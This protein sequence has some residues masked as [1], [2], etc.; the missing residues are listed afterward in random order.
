M[1]WW[2][3]F[4]GSS[5]LNFFI[6][7]NIKPRTKVEN[8]QKIL[9]SLFIMSTTI[10]SIF[11]RIDVERICYFDSFI[12][13]TVIGRSVATIGEISFGIQIAIYLLEIIKRLN[14][15]EYHNSLILF[16]ICI[17]I[18]QGVCWLGVLTK[19]QLFHCIEESIWTISVGYCIIPTIVEIIR[20]T[21]NSDSRLIFIT[22]LIACIMYIIFMSYID[23]PMYYKRYIHNEN[24]NM[25]YLTLS[26][27][28]KDCMSCN[29][30]SK[31]WDIWKED[32]YWMF[33][34]FS[35]STLFSLAMIQ[36]P[37]LF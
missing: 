19:Y 14:I 3:T 22:G 35:L 26:E 12:S 31:D 28:I 20:K 33:G 6:L 37:K 24:D 13:S 4:V 9:S 5:C 7:M 32:Y 2:L 25:K 30:I 10:R 34:Y 11:P 15:S 17:T 36:I 29:I 18:A 8:F 27:G 23:I 21:K 16:P 1:I